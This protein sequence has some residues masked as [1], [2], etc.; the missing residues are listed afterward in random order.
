MSLDQIIVLLRNRLAYNETRRAAAVA[1]GDLS[2]VSAVE[3]DSAS[4]QQSLSA[5]ESLVQG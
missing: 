5:L 4:T 1:R 2:E 3:A